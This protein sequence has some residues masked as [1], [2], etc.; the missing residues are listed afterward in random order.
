[1]SLFQIT[2]NHF[3]LDLYP[4]AKDWNGEFQS[5]QYPVFCEIPQE[6]LSNSFGICVSNTNEIKTA[7]EFFDFHRLTYPHE[8]FLYLTGDICRQTD[9][10]LSASQTGYFLFIEKGSF[11]SPDDIKRIVSKLTHKNF[12]LIEC[13][14][15]FGYADRVLDPRSLAAMKAVSP[16][17]GVCLTDLQAPINESYPHCADWMKNLKFIDSF[18]MAAEG[19]KPTFYVYKHQKKFENI[20][21]I[22]NSEAVV[23]EKIQEQSSVQMSQWDKF[24][25]PNIQLSRDKLTIIAG[26]CM[27]ET[28]ELGLE[29]GT[30][31]KQLCKELG[32]NYIFKSSFDKANRTSATG[33]RGPGMEQGLEWLKTIKE[34]LDVSVLT[35]VHDI[36]Q[37]QAAAKVVDVLQIPAFLF[38]EKALL[39]EC[40]KTKKTIQI[41]KG[42]WA[43][44]E[45]MLSIAQF[46]ADNNCHNITLVERGTCF[47][48]NNLVVDFRNLVDMAQYNHAVIYDATHA[49]QLPGAKQGKSS[50]LREMVPSLIKA[51]LGVGVDG[52]FM[53]VHPNPAQALSDADTQISYEMAKDILSSL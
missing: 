13:G 21:S 46:L 52:L 12:A 3:I 33:I 4:G 27:L 24:I 41:K 30:Y 11:L 44:A 14:S 48:Y 25:T 38:R 2:N 9:V 34:Q 16:Q 43:S 40:A 29:V 50:G 22:E 10:L 37:I 45:D 36:N 23:A 32:F 31:L 47:G 20:K 42:Q 19:F 39:L 28:L 7:Q 8:N 35:D 18:K 49:V 51:A 15:S 5:N 1:M 53:E 6:P 26:P 17:F